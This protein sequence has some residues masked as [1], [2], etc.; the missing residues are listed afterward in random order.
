MQ[1]DSQYSLLNNLRRQ[2]KDFE[3]KNEMHL[4]IGIRYFITG[5]LFL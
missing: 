3:A 4:N 1:S 5:Y 2:R